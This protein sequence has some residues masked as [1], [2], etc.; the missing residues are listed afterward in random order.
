M[1]QTQENRALYVIAVEHEKHGRDVDY[2]VTEVSAVLSGPEG[3]DFEALCR[4]YDAQHVRSG[5][6]DREVPRFLDWL[7][8]PERGIERLPH[9]VITLS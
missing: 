7:C 6:W 1:T 5:R 3:L 9:R 2:E 8:A 4:E